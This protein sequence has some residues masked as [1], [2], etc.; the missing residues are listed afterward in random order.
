MTLSPFA[1]GLFLGLISGFVV[2]YLVTS[3]MPLPS[4]A[5][6]AAVER[7]RHQLETARRERDGLL[8]NID[9][10]QE[11]AERMTAAFGHLE[12]RFLALE[13]RLA[14]ET[15]REEAAD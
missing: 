3:A 10:F 15:R 7:L 5:D 6:G 14:E 13:K 2:G 12:E 8:G 1:R 11:L 9:D 4:G